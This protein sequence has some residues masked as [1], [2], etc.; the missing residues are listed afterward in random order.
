MKKQ[1][2]I[3][4]ADEFQKIIETKKSELNGQFVIYHT[5]KVED[6]SRVG[7]SVGKKLGN[8]VF[9]NKTKRQVRM[10]LQD[11][12]TT[13]YS[14]DSVIIVRFK[15]FKQDFEANQ[16]SLKNLFDSIEKRRYRWINLVKTKNEYSC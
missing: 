3:T 7:I 15:Y 8:A 10:M 14:F 9:R 4:R 1:L 6:K 2:R 11:V 5:P 16:K 12:L 13:N